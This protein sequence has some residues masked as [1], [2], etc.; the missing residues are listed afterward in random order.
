MLTEAQGD[1][2][3]AG[4]GPGGSRSPPARQPRRLLRLTLLLGCALAAHL[5]GGWG[6]GAGVAA[7]PCKR[8]RAGRGGKRRT[9]QGE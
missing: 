6:S 7:A 4:P 3:G 8:G 1:G 2:D 9:G 5:A